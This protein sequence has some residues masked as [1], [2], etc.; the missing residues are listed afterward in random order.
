MVFGGCPPAANGRHHT[1]W[2]VIE[3]CAMH[4]PGA[5]F[6]CSRPGMFSAVTLRGEQV[7][8][9]EFT[10]QKCRHCAGVHGGVGSGVVDYRV[11]NQFFA[12]SPAVQ[13]VWIDRYV[14]L[15]M[16]DW[17]AEFDMDSASLEDWLEVQEFL[18]R[19]GDPC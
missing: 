1:I 6:G 17:T 4:V 9:T 8:W 14:A 7:V 11:L 13:Q 5:Y 12:A 18:H 2:H 15:H 19:R 10:Q 16:R 3:P